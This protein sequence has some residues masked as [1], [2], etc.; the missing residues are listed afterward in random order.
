[1]QQQVRWLTVNDACER[2]QC[3]KKSIYAAVRKGKLQAARLNDRGDLRFDPDWVDKWVQS[4]SRG[5]AA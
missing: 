1:M 3:G 5:W 4:C 2:A